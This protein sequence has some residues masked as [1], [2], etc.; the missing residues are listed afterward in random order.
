MQAGSWA[1]PTHPLGCASCRARSISRRKDRA[2]IVLH[3]AA[4]STLM[5]P[6]MIAA[7]WAL[8]TFPPCPCSEQH[9][10]MDSGHGMMRS[11][12]AVVQAKCY[13]GRCKTWVFRCGSI[14]NTYPCPLVGWMADI[15]MHWG[16]KWLRGC[17]KK[18]FQTCLPWSLGEHL[19]DFSSPSDLPMV[20]SFWAS[21]ILLNVEQIEVVW[22]GRRKG[23]GG[24]RLSVQTT[25][26]R[27][28][29][30]TVIKPHCQ[31]F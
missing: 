24:S 23:R 5:R 14:S 31:V 26:S 18:R 8:T 2:N 4:G 25:S 30:I 21:D 1:S 13:P 27:P 22:K 6:V 29:L 28:P 10:L 11:W 15:A 19:Q 17:K 7:T 3:R 9:Q 20:W 16:N 12:E